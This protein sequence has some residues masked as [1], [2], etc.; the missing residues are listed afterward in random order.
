MAREEFKI[1]NALDRIE[2][3]WETFTLEL[4]PYKKSFKLKKAE[5]VN[6][7]L[8]DHMGILST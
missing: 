5:D 6:A 3:K 7:V 8:E 4:E 2:S 1:E